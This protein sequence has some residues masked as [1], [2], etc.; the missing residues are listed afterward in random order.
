MWLP[1]A[2]SWMALRSMTEAAAKPPS[3]MA[4]RAAVIGMRP[5]RR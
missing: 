4:L 2:L 3:A 1:F 5:N